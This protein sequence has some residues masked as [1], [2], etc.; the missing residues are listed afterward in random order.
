[1][2]TKLFPESMVEKLVFVDVGSAGGLQNKWLPYRDQIFPVLFEPNSDKAEALRDA[3]GGKDNGEIVE[4]GLFN[5][6]G[7]QQL[8]I[9]KHWGCTSIRVPNRAT[10]DRY[11]FTDIF[12]VV[13]I[14][15]ID[16]KRYDH[17]FETEIVP[18]PDAIKIDVQGCEY[19]VL[20]GFGDLLSSCIGIEL[21]THFY[22]IYEGQYLLHDIVKFLELFGMRL[23]RLDR[24]PHFD[25]DLVEADVYFTKERTAVL[26]YGVSEM[27]KFLLLQK[28]WELPPYF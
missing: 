7:P 2:I 15:S 28:V 11:Q 16:C 12:N 14:K 24:V 5:K 9:T 19:E 23:R 20:E 8:N 26:N 6:N 25:G 21:E 4:L 18:Q 13:D 27:N 10:L 3:I 1:M 17:L 22:Q